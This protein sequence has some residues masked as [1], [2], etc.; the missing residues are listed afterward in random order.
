MA[1]E[2][3]LGP[4]AK[5][6]TL[7]GATPAQLVLRYLALEGTTTLFGVP[8][9]AVMQLL[10]ELRVH[11]DTFRFVVCRHE[12]GAAYMAD[13]YA[14]AGG[15]LGVTLVT[16]G[17]GATN[18]VTGTMNAQASGTPLLTISGEIQEQ[19]F[20]L[21][22]LQEGIDGS[23]DVNA[24]YD[25]SAG[26]TAFVDNALNFRA[27]FESALRSALSVPSGASHVS[28]PG[29]V[30]STPIATVSVPTSPAYYRAD[31][32]GSDAQAVDA[33]LDHLLAAERPL[34]FLGNGSTRRCAEPAAQPSRPSSSAS[35]C[36]S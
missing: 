31:P 3:V 14:R 12:T 25:A 34:I 11:E 29:D 18:A 33:A 20:G 35:R 10:Y 22:Y 8:G 16:S 27:L 5:S 13:G 1:T 19:Y 21:G 6:V 15:G 2:T 36:R 23:L 9:A 24:V 7:E 17:P 28:I 26:F 4:P 32:R 30:A